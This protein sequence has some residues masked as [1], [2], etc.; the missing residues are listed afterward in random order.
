[1]NG[2]SEDAAYDGTAPNLM[3]QRATGGR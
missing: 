2:E 3:E 1:M